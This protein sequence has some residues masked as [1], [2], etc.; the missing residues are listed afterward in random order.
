MKNPTS[1][2]RI[3]KIPMWIMVGVL[4]LAATGCSGRATEAA[5]MASTAD[6]PAIEAAPRQPDFSQYA[7]SSLKSQ[8]AALQVAPKSAQ[9][10]QTLDTALTTIGIAGEDKVY[11]DALNRFEV[12]YPDHLT[13]MRNRE[14]PN[15][16]HIVDLTGSA[17]TTLPFSV[18][19]YVQEDDGELGMLTEANLATFREKS[20]FADAAIAMERELSINGLPAVEQ[21]I[22]YSVAGRQMTMLVAYIEHPRHTI[23]VSLMADGAEVERLAKDF[24]AVLHGV[25]AR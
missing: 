12:T 7:R 23:S 6:A 10:P 16:V 3:C 19:I 8:D 15:A 21:L 2:R 5:P 18:N 14:S 24:H 1:A 22:T 11:Q 20:G 25:R 4:L 17:R 13:A 9:S